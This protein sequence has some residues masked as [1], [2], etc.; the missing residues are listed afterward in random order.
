VELINPFG[1]GGAA[2][3]QARKL[4]EILS[5]DLGQPVVVRNVPGAGGPSPTTRCRGAGR[6]VTP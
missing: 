6:T 2:D 1:A 4:A 3:V 5:Q